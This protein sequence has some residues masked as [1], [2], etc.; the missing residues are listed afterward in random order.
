[1]EREWPPPLNKKHKQNKT[2]PKPGWLLLFFERGWPPP[3]LITY[4]KVESGYPH[5]LLFLGS[6][7]P[8]PPLITY[9]NGEGV[10][11]SFTYLQ[12]MDLEMQLAPI[13]WY[14]MRRGRLIS[15]NFHCIL[16]TLQRKLYPYILNGQAMGT[17]LL[18]YLIRLPLFFVLKK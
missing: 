12:E 15:N 1:M 13:L 8:P 4:L 17:P 7:W 16:K 6:G 5:L 9:L 18:C 11:T 3:P 2:Q 14:L 10:A